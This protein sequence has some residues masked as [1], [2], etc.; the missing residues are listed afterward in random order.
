MRYFQ[1]KCCDSTRPEL[2][3]LLCSNRLLLRVYRCGSDAGQGGQKI[4]NIIMFIIS[5]KPTFFARKGVVDLTR[6][7]STDQPTLSSNAASE[8]LETLAYSRPNTG[9]QGIMRSAKIS[10]LLLLPGVLRVAGERDSSM[11]SIII[12]PL[13]A[14]LIAVFLSPFRII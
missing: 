4:P 1:L 6:N 7:D 11:V 10:F 5:S 2:S 8:N 12:C 9:L 13:A 14:V 3:S